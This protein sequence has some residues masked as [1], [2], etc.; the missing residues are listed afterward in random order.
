[1]SLD[2]V[3]AIFRRNMKALVVEAAARRRQAAAERPQAA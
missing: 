2:E 3:A 1:M